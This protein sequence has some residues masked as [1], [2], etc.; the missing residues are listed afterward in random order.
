MI[1]IIINVLYF[2][3]TVVSII[4]YIT[5][6]YVIS[7]FLKMITSSNTF[8]SKIYAVL[9]HCTMHSILSFL[10][11]WFPNPVYVKYDKEILSSNRSIF[12]ANNC[13]DFDWIFMSIIAQHFGKYE[14]LY[15]LMKRSI[16]DI[17]MVGSLLKK[18]KHMFLNRRREKVISLIHGY[19]KKFIKENKY[20]V[21]IFP[22]G[23]YTFSDSC[24]SAKEYAKKTNLKIQGTP[25]IPE[26]VLLPHKLGFDLIR[27]DLKMNYEGVIN[28]TMFTNPYMK[29]PSE[30]CSFTDLFIWGTKTINL[31]I[32]I[33]YVPKD[34]INDQFL[35]QTFFDKDKAIERYVDEFGGNISSLDDFK[36]LCNATGTIKSSDVLKT[37]YV[38]SKYKYFYNIL[39]VLLV[40]MIF[41][42]Y[43][44]I[45]PFK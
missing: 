43:S 42:I 45:S 39:P 17:P 40:C 7:M 38:T 31:A 36:K 19:M 21:L 35:N 13:T 20:C 15:I 26:R 34:K 32:V 10:Q 3:Y 16:L 2:A 41:C 6:A 27:G 24:R 11:Y 12:I 30:E 28:A 14:E 1:I 23:T 4:L 37:I 29:M 8:K 33:E 44:T 22:E 9:K 5:I 25:Y 18:F